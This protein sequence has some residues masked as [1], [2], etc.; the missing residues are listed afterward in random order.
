MAKKQKDFEE[1]KGA[2]A[3]KPDLDV[4]KTASSEGIEKTSMVYGDL[5]ASI[6]N[7]MFDNG[8]SDEYYDEF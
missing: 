3:V 5:G 1:G 6:Y 2:W 4:E 8:F 7:A